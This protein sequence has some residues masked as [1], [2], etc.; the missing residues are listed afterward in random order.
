MVSKKNP[1][2]EAKKCYFCN[3]APCHDRRFGAFCLRECK[4]YCSDRRGGLSR[5][6]LYSIFQQNYSCLVRWDLF[7]QYGNEVQ[8]EKGM[9][10]IPECMLNKSYITSLNYFR[11][12]FDLH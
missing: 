8:R 12:K 1:K 3:D 2:K 6:G 5:E 11:D 9:L 10:P 7:K 4:S